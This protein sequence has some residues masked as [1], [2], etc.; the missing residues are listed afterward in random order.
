[1]RRTAV[2]AIRANHTQL[3]GYAVYFLRALSKH[4][5]QILLVG[6]PVPAENLSENCRWIGADCRTL[7]ASYQ[8]GLDALDAPC[9]ELIFAS[10]SLMG[11]VWPLE[12]MFKAMADSPAA[13]WGAVLCHAPRR[14]PE[15]AFLV[16]RTAQ[17]PESFTF[18]DVLAL[19]PERTAAYAEMN[20][21]ADFADRPMLRYAEEALRLHR[22]PFFLREVFVQ[23]YAET[24]RA[25]CGQAAMELLEYLRAHSSYDT[26][27]IWRH[28]L[29]TGHQSDIVKNLHLNY[30]LPDSTPPAPEMCER[31]RARRILLVMHLYCEELFPKMHD[32]ARAMPGHAHIILT[33]TDER[34]RDLLAHLFSDFPEGQVEIRVLENRG[35]DVASIMVGVK[36]VLMDHDYACYVHDK[37]STHFKPYS[38][39]EAFAKK[40]LDNVLISREYVLNLLALFEDNPQ[41]GLLFPP[42]PDAGPYYATLG[43]E[44]GPN[45]GCTKALAGRLGI[46]VPLSIEKEPIAPMGSFYWFR[47]QAMR[48]L[49][50]PDWTYAD[51]P[52]EPV[53]TDGTLL[54]AIERIRPYA[55][56]Q[57]GYC[58]AYVLSASYARMEITNLRHYCR[59]LTAPV[60]ESGVNC[61]AFGEIRTF[62]SALVRTATNQPGTDAA[63]LRRQLRRAKYSPRALRLR[64]KRLLPKKAYTALIRAKR[65]LFGP[66][67]VEFHYEDQ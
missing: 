30:V 10:D 11:P 48:C 15:T 50:A 65:R 12:E 59:E 57:E 51:F 23:D 13:L 8:A 53:A 31:I 21:R 44:W 20:G 40:C 17:M 62:L 52:A 61:S 47:P 9:D 43:G 36:D 26:A 24:L 37:K 39:G 41:L 49:Y 14:F 1:M 5:Q 25:A 29:R 16:L 64:L 46:S 67:G 22:C 63:A 33:T 66:H 38:I 60:V 34:R 32:Y 4:V 56:Q 45:F 55:V 2:Y 42:E 18:A 7:E 28:I 3:D 19:P 35:R 27:L 58:P 6:T 54:H